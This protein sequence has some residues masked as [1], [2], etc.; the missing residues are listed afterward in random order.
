MRLVLKREFVTEEDLRRYIADNNINVPEFRCAVISMLMDEEGRVIFQRRGPESRDGNGMLAEIGGAVEEYDET[1]KDAMM[2]EL[3]EE[4]GESAL[5]NIDD[6]VGGILQTKYDPRTKKDVNWLFLL[7]KCTYVSGK[8]EC[9]EEGKSLGY[10][11]YDI[12]ELPRSEMLE[13][14]RYFW[15][16]YKDGYN[17]CYSYAM[18]I[19]DRI[20]NLDA[21][22]FNI[23]E[24]DG[25]YEIIFDKKDELEYKKFIIDNLEVGYWNEYFIDDKIV[26][27]FKENEKEV[28][29]YILSSL[30]NEEVLVK[31]REFAEADFVS[32]RQMFIDTPFYNKH[33]EGMVFYD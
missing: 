19:G 23:V 30:N 2:R 12:N 22:R 4:V 18:G 27:Y 21:S 8:L 20:K 16:Y 24:D 14:T 33:I 26:F 17:K 15:D 6:F 7:Y 28:R 10:E 25:D 5:I 1:L 32:I 29:R 11:V 13:T 9:N 31:C 3:R